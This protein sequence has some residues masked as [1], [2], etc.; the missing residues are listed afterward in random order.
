MS[1][2][3]SRPRAG[4]G[5]TRVCCRT[6]SDGESERFFHCHLVMVLLRMRLAHAWSELG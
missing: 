2:G 3:V 6:S 5:D 1:L 4:S